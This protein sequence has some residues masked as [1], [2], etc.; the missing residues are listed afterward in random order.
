MSKSRE[1]KNSIE[2]PGIPQTA[3]ARKPR[4]R[5]AANARMPRKKVTLA[6][7][8]D[9]IAWF[10]SKARHGGLDYNTHINQALRQYVIDLVGDKPASVPASLNERQRAEVRKLIDEVLTYKGFVAA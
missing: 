3:L 5:P 7:D 1:D 9:I 6:L 10:E 4:H 2:I 8:V